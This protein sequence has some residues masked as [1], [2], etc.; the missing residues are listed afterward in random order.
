MIAPLVLAAS[1]FVTNERA[2]TVQV[3]DT[4]RDVVV[5]SARIG[6][7]PRGIAASPDGKRIYVAQSWWRDVR[8]RSGTEAIVALDAKTLKIARRYESGS[9]PEVVVVSP[10]GRELY[11]SNEDAGNASIVDVTSGRNKATLVVGTEP[12]GV[13]VR[14][15]GR[16]VYVTCETSNTISVIHTRQRKVVANILVDARPRAAVF[17]SDNTRAWHS[18]ELGGSVTLLD[19]QKHKVLRR[20]KLGPSDKPVGLVLSPDEKRLYVATGRGN[21]VVVID[22]VAFKII[23]AIPVGER[24]WAIVLTRDGRKLYAANSLSNTISVIDTATNRVVKTI[25]TDDGPWGLVLSP[26]S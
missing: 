9:D 16:I 22:T 23:A 5:A 15:D 21:R 1:L 8:P 24:P 11:L 7:R 19:A 12:E 26:A 18:A 2:G 13:A 14:P 25:A 20:L 17:T 10:D 6:N 3:I 4:R